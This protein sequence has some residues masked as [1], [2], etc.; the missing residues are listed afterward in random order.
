MLFL[1]VLIAAPLAPV[2]V[3]KANAVLPV[4]LDLDTSPSG[5]SNWFNNIAGYTK[6]YV[7]NTLANMFI[8]EL[9]HQ[10]TLSIVNWI[11][12]GFQGS[13]A[14]VSD[15]QAF[16][17]GIG[18][19]IA[20]NFI[21][22]AGSPLAALCSPIALNV[23]LALA[24]DQANLNGNPYA[25]TLSSVINNVKGATI[26]GFTAGDFNQGGWQTFAALAEPQNS[27]YGA[28]LQSKADLAVQINGKT[29]LNQN[30]LNQGGGFLS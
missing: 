18:D 4:W 23:R 8:K 29:I 12:S 5:I 9:A 6:D 27:F 28:Y 11:N 14:F 24:L 13:P 2:S 26:N 25:C 17:E 10:I 21:G 20:G 7:L 15:P 22:G 3:K 1:T 30:L 19:N 16:F